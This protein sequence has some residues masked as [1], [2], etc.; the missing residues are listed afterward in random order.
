[1]KNKGFT[2][3][4]LLVV[5]AIIG[6]LAT[7]VLASLGS[8]RE[9]ANDAKRFSE[10]N[11]V[12]N[13]LELYYL[14]NNAYPPTGCLGRSSGT[15]FTSTFSGTAA[16]GAFSDYI[17]LEEFSS[18]SNVKED[19]YVFINN[20]TVNVNCGGGNVSGD[21]LLWN[22]NEDETPEQSQCNDVGAELACCPTPGG[23]GSGYFCATKID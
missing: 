8:A 5:V 1:M 11:Q 4:E 10:I 17:N 15:C 22:L 7:V 2:L 23:C 13:A 6:I 20:G 9:R 18:T 3:I 21:W 19:A 12:R 16:T 14:D